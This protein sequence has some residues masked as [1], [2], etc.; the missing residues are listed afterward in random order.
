MF[1]K[2]SYCVAQACVEVDTNF[3]KSSSCVLSACV[4]VDKTTNEKA[5]AIRHRQ[6]PKTV[7]TYSRDEWKTFIKGVKNGEFDID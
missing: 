1:K 7:I 2:S 4:E 3:K 6:T 5:V